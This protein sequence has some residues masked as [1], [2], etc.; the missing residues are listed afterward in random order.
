MHGR[1]P[2]LRCRRC[3][4]MHLH[5]QPLAGAAAA[6]LVPLPLQLL[7]QLLQ[8]ITLVLLALRPRLLHAAV[9]GAAAHK[10]R[11]LLNSP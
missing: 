10:V 7:L 4:V 1:K 11:L 6:G 8:R 5:L 3:W 2:T 9:V